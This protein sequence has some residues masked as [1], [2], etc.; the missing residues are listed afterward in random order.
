MSDKRDECAQAENMRLRRIIK[1]LQPVVDA[2]HIYADALANPNVREERR[3]RAHQAL[4]LA[5]SDETTVALAT[6]SMSD[7]LPEPD[8]KVIE[9]IR[10]AM[11]QR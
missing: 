11:W 3:V 6:A 9:A 10:A 5:V 8:H 4:L 7:G 2:A 1:R